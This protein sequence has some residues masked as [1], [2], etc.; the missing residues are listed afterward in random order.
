[1]NK[2]IVVQSNIIFPPHHLV[3]NPHIALNDLDDFGGDVLVGVIGDRE[4]VEAVTAEFHSGVDGLEEAFFVY[5][6]DDEVTL[7]DGFGPLGARPDADSRERMSD[8]GEERTL[9]RK[10]AAVT[11]YGKSI[12]LKAVVVMEAERL[13]ADDPRVEPEPACLKTV[14]A[15]GMAAVQHRHVVFLRH[16]IDCIEKAKEV[17]LR[18]YVLLPVGTQQNIFSFFETE[19]SMYVRSFYLREILVQYLC[20]RRTCDIRAFARQTAFRKITPCMFAVCHIHVRDDIHYSPVCLLRKTLVLAPVAG[21]HMEDRDM[22]PLCPDDAQTTVGIPENEH[23][24]RSCSRKKLVAAI[25][26]IAA[27]GT[28]VITHGIHIYFRGIELQILEKDPV[29]VVVVVLPGV[30]EDYIEIPAAFIDDGGKAD[31]F[32]P[33]AHDDDQFY[34]AVILELY[35]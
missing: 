30:G 32:R 12:H 15:A 8:T 16:R 35:I 27:C 10:S 24:V 21:L 33:R 23:S 18:V 4:A 25:D 9:L 26:Y 17:L 20:H 34:F 19:T 22:Q 1:M 31:D 6:G 3:H 7:V 2:Q 29:E 28:E 11:D 13:V 5:A 14:A